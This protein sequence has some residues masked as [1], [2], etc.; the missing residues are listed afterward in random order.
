[1]NEITDPIKVQ[2]PQENHR[3]APAWHAGLCPGDEILGLGGL[4]ART[5]GWR[6]LWE[7]TARVDRPLEVLVARQG[8]IDA[9]SVTPAASADAHA[10][11]VPVDEPTENALAHREAWLGA[12]DVSA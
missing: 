4:R 10:R 12:R 9:V 1:M 3:D 11:I 8:R 2:A 6:E 7:L 5:S